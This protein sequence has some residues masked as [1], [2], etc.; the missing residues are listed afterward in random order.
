MKLSVFTAAAL[1]SF[2][3]SIVTA[4]VPA[5]TRYYSSVTAA[6]AQTTQLSAEAAASKEE[7]MEMTRKVIREFMGDELSSDSEAA[8]SAKKEPAKEE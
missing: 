6:A 5:T 3:P 7:D 2:G 4:F 1:V 8:A